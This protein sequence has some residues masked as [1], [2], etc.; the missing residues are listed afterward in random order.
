[1]A[2]FITAIVSKEVKDRKCNPL[3]SRT[4]GFYNTYCE[5]SEA[6]NDNRGGYA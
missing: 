6:V 4:F 5:A 2:W 3:C 1:M